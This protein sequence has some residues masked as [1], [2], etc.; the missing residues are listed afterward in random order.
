MIVLIGDKM[1]LNAKNLIKTFYDT[2]K[3]KTI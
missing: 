1:E 3:D 2:Q